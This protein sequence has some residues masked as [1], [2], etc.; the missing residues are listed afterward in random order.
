LD[1][2]KAMQYKTVQKNRPVMISYAQYAAL[3]L[4]VMPFAKI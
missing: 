4:C 3:R 2:A 1:N